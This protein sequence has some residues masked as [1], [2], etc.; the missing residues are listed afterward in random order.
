MEPTKE[1]LEEWWRAAEKTW[2]TSLQLRGPKM[3]SSR[4]SYCIRGGRYGPLCLHNSD[5]GAG[6]FGEEVIATSWGGYMHVECAVQSLREIEA[7]G[8]EYSGPM[9]EMAVKGDSGSPI[10]SDEQNG[11]IP[12]ENVTQPDAVKIDPNPVS[13]ELDTDAPS[14]IRMEGAQLE[15][16]LSWATQ[17]EVNALYAQFLGQPIIVVPKETDKSRMGRPVLRYFVWKIVE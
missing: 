8:W 5:H 12:E 6:L 2:Q 10:M 15:E 9:F 7:A 13:I 16:V 1:Q 14:G 3:I 4:P 17:A 11:T